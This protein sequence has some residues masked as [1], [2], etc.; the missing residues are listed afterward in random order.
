[1]TLHP[2]DDSL[3][4]ILKHYV[5][6]YSYYPGH[7]NDKLTRLAELF[8]SCD[9]EGQMKIAEIPYW[10][11]Y[12][13]AYQTKRLNPDEPNTFSILQMQKFYE[14]DKKKVLVNTLDD[15]LKAKINELNLYIDQYQRYPNESL[16]VLLILNLVNIYENGN[17]HDM[18]AILMIKY[19]ELFHKLRNHY[20]SKSICYQQ[21]DYTVSLLLQQFNNSP[22][23]YYHPVIVSPRLQSAFSKPSPPKPIPVK[24]STFHTSELL[25]SVFNKSPPTQE[26]PDMFEF[27][28]LNNIITYDQVV[29]LNALTVIPGKYKHYIMSMSVKHAYVNKLPIKNNV[30]K[31]IIANKDNPKVRSFLKDLKKL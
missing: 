6:V 11:F 28:L 7:L 2:N 18:N 9:L 8:D 21:R 14:E 30:F 19:W 16:I 1:M 17:V 26:Q 24:P 5:S 13:V 22:T 25:Q 29:K 20:I 31:W 12:Y 27:M 15:K 4:K 10:Y 23:Y 3:I